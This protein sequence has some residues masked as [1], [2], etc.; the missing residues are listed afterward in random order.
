MIK[1]PINYWRLGTNLIEF[2]LGNHYFCKLKSKPPTLIFEATK[3]VERAK[4]KAILTHFPA[5]SQIRVVPSVTFT[6]TSTTSAT[7]E[8]PP[9]RSRSPF[10]DSHPVWLQP[11]GLVG[12]IFRLLQRQFIPLTDTC[13]WTPHILT[14]SHLPLRF[15][16]SKYISFAYTRL[17]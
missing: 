16:S 13:P 2:R 1:D 9:P 15:A 4:I 14:R 7:A 8:K 5:I 10:S 12:V 3:R 6:T 11:T 17:L